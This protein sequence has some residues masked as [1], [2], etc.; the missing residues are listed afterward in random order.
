MPVSQLQ[1]WLEL[2]LPGGPPGGE[3]VFDCPEFVG[4]GH[5][6][7]WHPNYNLA[8]SLVLLVTLAAIVV[9]LTFWNRLTRIESIDQQSAVLAKPGN[10]KE[11]IHET[12]TW[13]TAALAKWRINARIDEIV[14]LPAI[15]EAL[16]VKTVSFDFLFLCDIH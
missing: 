3:N 8:S 1:T 11:G 5:Y 12:R 15:Y 10:D 6:P 14:D 9:I 13:L 7:P 4:H 2:F 16:E